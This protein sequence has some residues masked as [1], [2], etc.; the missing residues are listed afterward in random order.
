MHSLM[1]SLMQP[2][3][4]L[5][6]KVFPARGGKKDK[7]IIKKS[8]IKSDMKTNQCMYS[9]TNVVNQCNAPKVFAGKGN[10]KRKTTKQKSI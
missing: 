1:H 9:H 8:I 7:N 5:L 3:A 10:K 4:M 2:I 6:I